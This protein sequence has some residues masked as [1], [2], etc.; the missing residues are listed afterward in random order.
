MKPLI[1]V[2]LFIASSLAQEKR[3]DVIL[4]NFK[5]WDSLRSPREKLAFTQG[6]LNGYFVGPRSERFLELLDCLETRTTPEKT[7][8]IVDKY[9][10]ERPWT[11]GFPAGFGIIEALTLNED[12]PCY[13][14]HPSSSK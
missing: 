2:F 14:Y 8:A 12:S 7:V 10:V 1:A 3:S 13:G 11:S 5:S 9:Y 4:H 6:F